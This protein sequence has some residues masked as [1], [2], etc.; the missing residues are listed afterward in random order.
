MSRK[1][2]GARTDNSKAVRQSREAIVS[3]TARGLG[4]ALIKGWGFAERVAAAAQ[5]RLAVRPRATRDARPGRETRGP[6]ISDVSEMRSFRC[7]SRASPTWVGC[8]LATHTVRRRPRPCSSSRQ[9]LAMLFGLLLPHAV[10][11]CNKTSIP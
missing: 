2:R 6:R 11:N 1:E 9:A 8:V 7:P 10:Q 3:R 5:E 4:S